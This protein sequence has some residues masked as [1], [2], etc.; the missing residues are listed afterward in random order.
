[1]TISRRR[2]LGGAAAIA[3]PGWGA[4]AARA[5]TA[6][7]LL[8]A[9]PGRA[10]LAPPAYP[11][12]PVWSYGGRVPGPV[13]RV[14]RGGRL[15]RRFVNDLPQP[16]TIHWHGVRLANAMDG[17]PELTQ[18][19]VPPGGDFLYDFAAP[20]AG[21]FWYHPHHRSWEQMAR[22]LY[23][24]LIVEEPLPPRVDRDEVLLLDDWRLTE[25]ARIHESFGAMRDWSHAGRVGNWT[26]V[27][28]EGDFRLRVRQ[29]ERLRLR[30]VN[31]ANAR[32][33]VLGLRG[34]EGFVVALDGQPLEAPA[35]MPEGRITLAPAQRADLI[36]DLTAREGASGR[37]VSFERE[38]E[39]PI[40]TLEV[41]GR[42]RP[43]RL[44]P[45]DALPANP[46]PPLGDL[47]LARR[48]TLRMEGG[49]MGRM[50]EAMLE[51]RMTELRELVRAGR[52]W[53]F[54]GLAEMPEEPFLSAAHGETLRVAM[55]N[56][57]AWPHAMHLHGH[58]FRRLGPDGRPGPWRDTLLIDRNESAEIAF[59][60]DNPG[61]WLLH[62][63]M[64][65]HAAAGMRTWLRVDAR[66]RS[67]AP[68]DP[69]RLG[70]DPP[71]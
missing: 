61:D 46:L 32:V 17:V 9:A 64:L 45:P 7:P 21:T 60:A 53:A 29:G 10:Q 70:A 35:P 71:A 50:R 36:A 66:V 69:R 54:N 31:T 15:A 13:L 41:A 1:M 19:P 39:R 58:H 16:S 34:M 11:E 59:V 8:R 42:I 38:Q 33:F 6:P 5:A 40:A 57:T 30:L 65:E 25:E 3:L 62:C 44:P 51:G 56:D 67:E 4:V 2:L 14:A 55:H 12:T 22:G 49:A 27:N 43:R 52:V 63:H 28:G 47:A 24:A 18:A 23:G 68:A 37:I 26:T 20:D 48:A